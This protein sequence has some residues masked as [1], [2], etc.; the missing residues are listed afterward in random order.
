MV[1][2]YY[3]LRN[4]LLEILLLLMAR[5][6]SGTTTCTGFLLATINRSQHIDKQVVAPAPT[7][8]TTSAATP[9]VILFSATSSTRSD[10][11]SSSS[12]S[13][14]FVVDPKERDTQYGGNNM[15]QYLVDLHD[16]QATF[17]FCGGMLFQ[18]VL[19][20]ALREH[21]LVQ[22]L[23]AAAASSASQDNNNDHDDDNS[24]LAVAGASA[25]RMHRL[26]SYEQ[27]A[28]ADNRAMTT[29]PIQSFFRGLL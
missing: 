14:S 5:G 1:Y 13:A 21:Y 12:S 16:S 18:L 11:A 6:P 29:N 3:P 9:R 23:S 7:T 22:L 19:S 17:D 4:F 27:S 15:A 28:A 20:D 26:S 25:Y 8:T 2:Y 10:T 24:V